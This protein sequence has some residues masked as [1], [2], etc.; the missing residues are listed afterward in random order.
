MQ[1]SL[2]GSRIFEKLCYYSVSQQHINLLYTI[3]VVRFYKIRYILFI[4]LWMIHMKQINFVGHTVE[5]KW[6]LDSHYIILLFV[7]KHSRNVLCVPDRQ[8]N[9]TT[10]T[11]SCTTIN[12]QHS[13][14]GNVNQIKPSRQGIT[15]FHS[16][17]YSF[18]QRAL[19]LLMELPHKQTMKFQWRSSIFQLQK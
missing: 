17:N 2:K 6:I 14:R 12:I 4:L 15:H 1:Y 16:Q 7:R 9:E 5:V 11:L 10:A 19:S 13:K 18:H 3:C 8:R